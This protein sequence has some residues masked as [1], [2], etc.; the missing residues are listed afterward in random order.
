[1]GSH[2]ISFLPTVGWAERGSFSALGHGNSVPRCHFL[3][4]TGTGILGPFLE[5][6]HRARSAGLLEF[7]DRHQ[8][9]ELVISDGG[10]QGVHGTVLA[11]GW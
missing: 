9:D 6:A 3:W 7:R 1:V 5:S 10:V 11:P 8:V 2:G 4:G